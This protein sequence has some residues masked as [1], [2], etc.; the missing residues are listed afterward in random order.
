MTTKAKVSKPAVKAAAKPAY[1]ATP[2]DI[3][4]AG[5]VGL[6]LKQGETARA[7]VNKAV[8][9]LHAHGAVI[10]DARTCPL[11]QA[12][13]DK[14]FPGGKGVTGKKVTAGSMANA[15]NAFRAAVKSGKAYNENKGR[16]TAKAAGK[17]GA[18]VGGAI[19]LSFPAGV[20]ADSI[21]DKMDKAI[22]KMKESGNE[23]LIRLAAY[24]VDALDEFKA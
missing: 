24:L 1:V 18:K 21:A 16:E 11:A 6:N 15:L 23:S 5:S 17:K 2:A 22:G 19:V 10:G 4:L 13:I 8:S 14:R 3:N 7:A 20:K 12:F 9:E